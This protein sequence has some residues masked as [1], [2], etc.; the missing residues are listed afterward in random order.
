MAIICV[1]PLY[2]VISRIDIT[3][4]IPHRYLYLTQFIFLFWV[5]YKFK[6]ISLLL[7]KKKEVS[8]DNKINHN[9]CG[10]FIILYFIFF[11]KN[12]YNTGYFFINK[13]RTQIWSLSQDLCW[14]KKCMTS[15]KPE[16][17]LYNKSFVLGKFFFVLL[18]ISHL[19]FCWTFPKNNII[20]GWWLTS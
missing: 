10:L 3:Y 13:K 14:S 15:L 4:I 9:L 6:Y 12:I 17:L 11:P 16:D 7:V 18:K 1:F 19:I 5:Y 8:K 2:I 20:K